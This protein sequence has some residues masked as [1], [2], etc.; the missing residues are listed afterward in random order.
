MALFKRVSEQV[1]IAL[2]TQ[3]PELSAVRANEPHRMGS[4]AISVFDHWLRDQSEWHL[5]DCFEGPERLRRDAVFLLHW[6]AI[7]D[8]ISV[9]TVRSRGRPPH[10]SRLVFKQY[11]EKYGYLQQCR[12]DQRRPPTQL[13]LLPEFDSIYAASW[14]DTNI[15]YFNSRERAEPI[16]KL[17]QHV[18]LHFLEFDA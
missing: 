7:F 11:S 18:G 9:F 2:H 3:F 6:E 5:M 12:I 10:R 13:V 1:H 17:A 8:A 15:V 4:V 14:D 16:L